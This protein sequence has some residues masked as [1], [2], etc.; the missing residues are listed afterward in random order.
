MNF[1]HM[2]EQHW[3]VGYPIALGLKVLSAVAP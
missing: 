1:E 2:P 3:A